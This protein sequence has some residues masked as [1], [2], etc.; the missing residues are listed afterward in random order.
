M[1]V[2]FCNTL[3][4]PTIF[5]FIFL[6]VLRRKTS[7]PWPALPRLPIIGT[8]PFVDASQFP[9]QCSHFRKKYGPIFSYKP[10]LASEVLVVCGAR[11][12]KELFIT[13]SQSF[14]HRYCPFFYAP[15]LKLEDHFTPL[16]NTSPAIQTQR[17]LIYQAIRS[18]LM[19]DE[20]GATD[21]ASRGLLKALK[22]PM[23]K[24][25][26][27]HLELQDILGDAVGLSALSL[28]YGFNWTTEELRACKEVGVLFAAIPEYFGFFNWINETS[29]SFPFLTHV[30]AWR[31]QRIRKKA[32]D[33]AQRLLVS[34]QG[35][36]ELTMKKVRSDGVN[37]LDHS[38]A[39]IILSNPDES[40]PI[41]RQSRLCG[42]AATAAF[43][44]T[45]GTLH[46]FVG[47]LAAYPNWQAKLQAE[48]DELTQ[49]QILSGSSHGLPKYVPDKESGSACTVWAFINEVLRYYP[50]FPINT[51]VANQDYTLLDGRTI[52]TGQVLFTVPAAINRDPE[53][54]K[55]PDRFDPERF[56]NN[57]SYYS[58]CGADEKVNW[59]KYKHASFGSGR[60]SCPGSELAEYSLFVMLTRLIYCFELRFEDGLFGDTQIK[61][62]LIGLETHFSFPKIQFYERRDLSSI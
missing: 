58:N 62:E 54:H 4:L 55:D 31:S 56:L 30:L 11:L 48:V 23:K 35:L 49:M 44:T 5:V 59:P 42:S 46:L 29:V 33:A 28:S 2:L 25:S 43:S 61:S 24:L 40:T 18:S 9:S 38:V 13:N 27:T 1:P 50:I 41:Y 6:I 45:A 22:T 47:C 52:K 34:Y 16:L 26:V 60:R 39:R 37:S 21:R 7:K 57:E 17:R 32:S 51:R 12:A 8:L 10:G 53:F 15:E 14:Q 36:F 19:Q 3:S 20:G